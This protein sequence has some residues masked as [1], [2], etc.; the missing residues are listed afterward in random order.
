M[1][2]DF[3][4]LTLDVADGV[5]TITLTQGDRGNPFDETLCAEL[6]LA[7]S[8]C[9]SDPAVRAVL[10]RAEGRFFSVGGDLSVLG[11]SREELPRFVSRATIGFHS[12]VSRFA[13]MDAPV[14]VAVHGLAAGG[15][16]SLLAG[17]DFVLSAES[18]KFYAAYQGIGLA[19]DGGGSHHLP[20]RVGS[21]RATSF[22]LRNETWTAEQAT[23]YGLVTE[24]HADEALADA[25]TALAKTLAAGPTL[26]YGEVKRLLLSTWDQPLETQLELEAQAMV[27]AGRSDDGWAGISA[28]AARETPEFRGS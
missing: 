22:Y 19:I 26:A 10:I 17:A 21:R 1:S 2:H 14:V 13:R 11:A 7:A 4:S 3:A 24:T 15:G 23:S 28:V 18:A 8:V 5:A 27:R 20:R 16:V 6:G 9:D 25:A 12:A